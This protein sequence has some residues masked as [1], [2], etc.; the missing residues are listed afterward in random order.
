MTKIFI[1]YSHADEDFLSNNLI[2]MLKELQKENIVEYFYDRLLRPDGELFDT[3]DYHMKECDIAI[4]LLSTS[5][6]KSEA[7]K[8]EKEFLLNRKKLEGIYF[9]PI[10]VSSC[11]WREDESIK[12]SLFL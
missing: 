1:S 2:L 9:L 3:L 10:V 8:K 5:Y 4:V 6:Y 7:C 12:N 11:N